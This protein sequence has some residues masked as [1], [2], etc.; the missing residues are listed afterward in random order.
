MSTTFTTNDP[1]NKNMFSFLM[2]HDTKV[3]LYTCGVLIIILLLLIGLDNYLKGEPDTMGQQFEQTDIEG[4]PSGILLP[5]NAA[6][7]TTDEIV[8]ALFGE[9]FEMYSMGSSQDIKGNTFM[10]SFWKK[11]SDKGYTVVVTSSFEKKGITC[12]ISITKNVQD[13]EISE[14]NVAPSVYTPAENEHLMVF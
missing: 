9:G 1:N 8:I 3:V 10:M 12:I 5:L 14:Q 7:D 13:L 6:C 11:L 2:S 4:S